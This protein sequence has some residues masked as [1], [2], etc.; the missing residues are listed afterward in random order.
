MMPSTHRAVLIT[1][2]NFGPVCPLRERHVGQWLFKKHL[3][4]ISSLSSIVE[5]SS[6]P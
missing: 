5:Y 3:N 1:D 2:G 4:S 6:F